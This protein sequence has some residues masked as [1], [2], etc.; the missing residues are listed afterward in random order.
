MIHRVRISKITPAAIEFE[1]GGQTC[2]AAN[3]MDPGEASGVVAAGR[4]YPLE[5]TVIADGEVAYLAEPS[6]AF[7]NLGP[8]YS[9]LN[10]STG[11]TGSKGM[12]RVRAC[13]RIMDYLAHDVIRLDGDVTVAVKLNLPQQATDYRRGSWLA[14]VGTLMA[15]MPSPD[16]DEA[17]LKGSIV[18]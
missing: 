4:E 5:L 18:E 3:A 1:L 9:G 17:G 10:G 2:V 12:T 11:P 6:G 16:H 14:A 8:D 13:G 7:A 15:T